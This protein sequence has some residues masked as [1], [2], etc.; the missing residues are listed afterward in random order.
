[1]NVCDACNQKNPGSL[2]AC[3]HCG[4]A[5]NPTRQ[6]ASRGSTGQP[7]FRSSLPQSGFG[8]NQGL[9]Q[10]RR[11]RS[12]TN[13]HTIGG[14]I[15]AVIG[16]FFFGGVLVL[17]FGGGL[18]Q[19]MGSFGKTATYKSYVCDVSRTESRSD[20]L[21]AQGYRYQHLPRYIDQDYDRINDSC[22]VKSHGTEYPR[23]LPMGARVATIYVNDEESSPPPAG[24]QP[25]GA[26]P[27]PVDQD[28]EAAPTEDDQDG[29]DQPTQQF[30]TVY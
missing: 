3:A 5:L 8:Q 16:V 2:S 27:F 14:P 15:G 17:F 9:G 29:T 11:R 30:N 19:V 28:R 22:W 10:R 13:Q 1:M 21:R 12:G 7:V 24:A 18:D 6:A 26:Q 4:A 20:N 23:N 25:A